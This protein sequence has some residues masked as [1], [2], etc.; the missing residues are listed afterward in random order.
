MSLPRTRHTDLVG[1]GTERTRASYDRV[2]S[3]YT[4]AMGDELSAKP[5]DR[6]FLDRVAAA[7]P[8]G[9][10]AVD[11]GC[12]PGQV[13]AALADRGVGPVVALDLS[14]PMVAEARSRDGRLTPV[15]AD[16][17]APPFASG[18]VGAVVA[19]YSLL[20][21]P[22]EAQEAAVRDLAAL[23]VPGGVFALALHVGEGTIHLDEW[24]GERVDCDFHLAS[25]DDVAARLE[26]AGLDVVELVERDPYPEVEAQT[27]RVYALAVRPP[28]SG[29]G[30]RTHA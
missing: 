13:A 9:V 11:V 14:L 12:G 7:V 30:Q 20:H 22:P 28:A 2:A 19:F 17:V 29:S 25:T 18:S 4:A 15:Q 10:P 5:F 8:R 6:A 16:L 21:V 27:R 26:R 24:F 3:H 23:L 1:G